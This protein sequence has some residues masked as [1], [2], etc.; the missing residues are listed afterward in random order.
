M[1]KIPI[2][3]MAFNRADHV[4]QSMAIIREYQPER[5]YLEADGPRLNKPGEKEA[6]EETRKAMLEIVD[7]PCEV[8]TLFRE[9]NL[10]CAKAVYGAISWFL[11]NEE[12]GVIC[13]DD[14]L[15]SP[16]FFTL[17]EDLLPKYANNDRI[18]QIAAFNPSSKLLLS[19]T[20][21]FTKRPQIWGWATWRR[22][23]FNNMDM[24]MSKWAHFRIWT[25]VRY[26]G[27]LQ[28]IYMWY[29][30]NQV[31]HNLEYSTS[32]ATRWHFAALANGLV[33]ICPGANLSLNIGCTSEGAHYNAGDKDPYYSKKMGRI[34]FPLKQPKSVSLDWIQ[35]YKDNLD[36]LRVRRIGLIKK[37]KNIL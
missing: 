8:K 1:K 5:L 16:D 11:E 12:F 15:L 17:C 3:I 19:D 18:Q 30:W 33:S 31:Y 2:L 10:G 28:G 27:V 23:W 36:F 14:I 32:W 22:A 4:K 29:N 35:L 24:S 9:E 20:Y 7:W 25:I 21:T 34:E 13:E 6:C 37:I 26:Y